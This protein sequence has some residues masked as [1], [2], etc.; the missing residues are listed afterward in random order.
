MIINPSPLLTAEQVDSIKQY[1]YVTTPATERNYWQVY[2]AGC[3]PK[4][5]AITDIPSTI[6]D[7]P[8][9]VDVELRLITYSNMVD[10]SV[11]MWLGFC[12]SCGTCH[13]SCHDWIW[14][15]WLSDQQMMEMI[16]R[17]NKQLRYS[18]NSNRREV[19]VKDTMLRFD[20]K[21]KLYD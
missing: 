3:K 10:Q 14:L 4:S 18:L 19:T 6:T 11:K 9:I 13:W 8:A 1:Q 21:G 15:S 12:N 5:T 16:C 2:C 20:S 7:A 17:G